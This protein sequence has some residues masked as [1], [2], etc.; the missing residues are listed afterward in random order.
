M[1]RSQGDIKGTIS[2]NGRPP[3]DAPEAYHRLI[4]FVQ[5][6]DVNVLIRFVTVFRVHS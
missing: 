1:M 4:G 6:G 2:L 3:Q 5:Q